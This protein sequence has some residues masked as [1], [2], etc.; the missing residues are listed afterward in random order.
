MTTLNVQF[1]DSTDE[2]IISIFGCAQDTTVYPNQGTIDTSDA[3]YKTYF[4]TLPESVQ[5][6]LPSPQ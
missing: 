4:A 2:T 6:T 5:P 3:R 1:A